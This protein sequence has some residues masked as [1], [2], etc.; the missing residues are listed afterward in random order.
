MSEKSRKSS[1]L[2]YF[3]SRNQENI[4]NKIFSHMAK[5]VECVVEL[6]K[7]LNFL[8]EEKNYDL[9]LKV[10]IRV[11]DLEHQADI[12]RREILN[13]LS[14]VELKTQVHE[15]LS[16]LI[17]RIDD[18]ADAASATSRIIIYLNFEDLRKIDPDVQK[19]IIEIGVFSVDCVKKLYQMLEKMMKYDK[20]DAQADAA[21][22]NLIE[23]K[24]DEIHFSMNRILVN[25][26]PNY[27]INPFSAY[28]IMKMLT[29]LE[30]ITDAAENVADYLVILNIM[31]K[32]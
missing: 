21:E 7:A 12:I 3:Q 31:T 13:I 11:N 6:Q 1:L 29:K 2:E 28:E 19:K 4:I 5:V 15:N 16:H 26:G 14:Q 32:K 18:V 8:F 22:I 23:H 9:A 25:T 30:N 24:C 10:F 17:K 20:Y 27:N